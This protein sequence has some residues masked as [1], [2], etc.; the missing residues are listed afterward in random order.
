MLP[1]SK[2]FPSYKW[3]WL[4]VQPTEGL[5][6]APVFLGV[7]RAAL[8]YEGERYS[9]PE[10]SRE[11]KRVGEETNCSSIN[12]ARTPERN[13][14]RN[15]GQYWRGTGLLEIE[16]GKVVLT[17]LGR[18]LAGG[19]ITHDEFAALMIRNTVLPNPKTYRKSEIQKWRSANLRLKPFALILDLISRLRQSAGDQEAYLTPD[20]LIRI[21]IPLA[22]EMN[23][24]EVMKSSILQFRLGKLD[25]AGWP[26]CAPEA[27]DKR[28]AREFLLFLSN[29]GICTQVRKQDRY[30]DQFVLCEALQD[31]FGGGVGVSFLEN[32]SQTDEEIKASQ[33]SDLPLMIERR[34]ISANVL[35]RSAQSR[36]RRQVLEAA[37]G[38]CLM[39]GETIKDVLEAAHVMP[40]L[41]GGSDDVENGLCLRTD[42]HRLFDA[43]KIRFRPDGSINFAERVLQSD[44]YNGLPKKVSF[45]SSV[46]LKL[47][48]WRDRYL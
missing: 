9:F 40:V 35:A 16:P 39:T 47:I 4:S 1:P 5:L 20:E 43:G 41:D 23:D 19:L 46:S 7:L 21:V 3:R 10:L 13:I 12:L 18:K 6:K 25:L 22:G 44:S 14:F 8:K 32:P 29:F 11:L 30:Q 31:N 28:L 24:Q 33:E 45:P 37:K 26:N 27:N 17:E 34:R 38:K 2:P 48:E 15:S 36:F 42:I